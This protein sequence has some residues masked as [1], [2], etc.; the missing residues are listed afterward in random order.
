MFHIYQ[1]K[2]GCAIPEGYGLGERVV[3]NMTD[4]LE[5]KHHK[6][7]FDNNFTSPKLMLALQEK[8]IHACGTARLRKH[9]L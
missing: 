7:Y 3:L 4:D 5:D 2:N 9:G 6:T 8:A 1:A